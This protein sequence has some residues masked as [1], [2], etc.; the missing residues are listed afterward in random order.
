MKHLRMAVRGSA[1]VEY[2]RGAKS[3]SHTDPR[4][5]WQASRA[6]RRAAFENAGPT[7]PLST[8]IDKVARHAHKVTDDDRKEC[9]AFCVKW[10]K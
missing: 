8:L 4:R 1:S 9:I 2:Q 5:R 10:L 3:V 7:G 6:Q